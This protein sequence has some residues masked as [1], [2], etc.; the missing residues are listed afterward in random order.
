MT[1]MKAGPE[2][3]RSTAAR[4]KTRNCGFVQNLAANCPVALMRAFTGERVFPRAGEGLCRSSGRS[5]L[6][7]EWTSGHLSAVLLCDA[8]NG[9]WDQAGTNWIEPAISALERGMVSAVP[10][11]WD[12]SVGRWAF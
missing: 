5:P 11:V 7:F 9:Q 2:A 8:A 6:D 10:V 1:A 4:M 12:Q 3:V